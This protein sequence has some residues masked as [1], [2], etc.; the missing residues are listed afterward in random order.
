MKKKILFFLTVVFLTSYIGYVQK[1][2]E[3]NSYI[4]EYKSYN[5]CENNRKEEYIVYKTKY[6]KKYHKYGCGYLR[7][8]CKQITIEKAKAEGLTPCSV[9]NP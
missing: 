5:I 9:C 8:S 1:D 6:G 3:N 7:L 4:V 2:K